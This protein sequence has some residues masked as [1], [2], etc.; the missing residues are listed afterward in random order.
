MSKIP[1]KKLI[2]I[3][4]VSGIPDEGI[5][6]IC[7]ELDIPREEFDKFIFG[8]TCGYVPNK[9]LYYEGDVLKFLRM[10]NKN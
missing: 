5:D 1:T 9:V 8:Q 6:N 2:D 7:K 3:C 10:M 4:T